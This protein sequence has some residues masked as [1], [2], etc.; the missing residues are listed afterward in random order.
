VT[1]GKS[2]IVAVGALLGLAISAPTAFGLAEGP[3]GTPGKLQTRSASTSIAPDSQASVT[4]SC[5]RGTKAFSGGFELVAPDPSA[6]FPIASAGNFGNEPLYAAR[7]WTS[8]GVNLGDDPAT[9]TSYAYCRK[10]YGG[11]GVLSGHLKEIQLDPLAEVSLTD[12]CP[13][14]FGKFISVGF[15]AEYDE[16]TSVFIRSSHRQ[17]KFG[18]AVGAKAFGSDP[19]T[20]FAQY[21]CRAF[22]K[23]RKRTKTE[24]ASGADPDSAVAKCKRGQ[25]VVSGGFKT[26]NFP[27]EGGPFVY[28][29]RK[30]GRRGWLVRVLATEPEE[31][32]SYA[33]CEK[34]PAR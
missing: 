1:T 31:F 10:D 34:N 2:T 3:F 26:E 27:S 17:G 14:T 7:R 4:A 25:R 29:S 11:W 18:W 5:K 19:A 13:S 22:T 23:L 15:E 33:Y 9:L 20:L 21:S 24:T 30:Q 28:A 6:L 16:D 32:T 12:R 8:A